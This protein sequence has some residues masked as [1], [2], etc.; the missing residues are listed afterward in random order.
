MPDSY[1][2]LPKTSTKTFNDFTLWPSAFYQWD[3]EIL[4]PLTPAEEEPNFVHVTTHMQIGLPRVI[5][6]GQ[7]STIVADPFQS[8]YCTRFE[9]QQMKQCSSSEANGLSRKGQTDYAYGRNH[10]T[11]NR[12]AVLPNI[13]DQGG[14]QRRR[15][16]FEP[17]LTTGYERKHRRIRGSQI[18]SKW[19]C[20][21]KNNRQRDLGQGVRDIEGMRQAEWW[22]SR[23]SWAP[24]GEAL[25]RVKEVSIYY[26]LALRGHRFR[27][28]QELGG[29][30]NFCLVSWEEVNDTSSGAPG[31]R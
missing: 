24:S 16:T 25:Y 21:N 19:N 2:E 22:D 31:V 1:P 17:G 13:D 6:Y 9:I 26:T 10:K 27:N 14:V 15:A 3:M 30:I 18:K 29:W 8:C 7:W 20:I 11:R 23:E 4:G 12:H 5:V 28:Y